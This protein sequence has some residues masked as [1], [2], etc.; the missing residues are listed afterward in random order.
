M[1][2]ML[3]T[4]P[5]FY[6]SVHPSVHPSKYQSTQPPLAAPAIHVAVSNVVETAADILFLCGI[7][8]CRGKYS[9]LKNI[10][11]QN[12]LCELKTNYE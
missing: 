7:F 8:V 12:I 1:S 10:F 11:K 4:H 5:S 3:S 6:Q 2:N 9:I